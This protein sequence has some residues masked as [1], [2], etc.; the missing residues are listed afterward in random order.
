MKEL[1]LTICLLIL[2][3]GGFLQAQTDK[4]RVAV[5][6]PTGNS[7]DEGIIMATRELV[8]SALVNTG[9]YDIVERSLLDRILREQKF[10]NSGAVDASQVSELGRLVGANK[11]VLAVVTSMGKRALLSIKMVDVESAMVESQKTKTL[12]L[13]EL[14]DWIEPLTLE[15]IG[16]AVEAAPKAGGVFSIGS[17][18]DRKGN[19]DKK[20][21]KEKEKQKQKEKEKEKEKEKVVQTPPPPKTDKERFIERNEEDTWI[22]PAPTTNGKDVVFEFKG[23]KGRKNPIVKLYLDGSPIG[24]GTLNEGFSIKANVRPGAYTIKIEWENTIADTSFNINT[25]KKHHYEFEYKTTG[26]GY[27]FTLKK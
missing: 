9:K 18:F 17:L 4:S 12:S 6:D 8:S 20:A 19:S 13:D 24:T 23:A 7:L 5:F 2:G 14:L 21:S 1:V 3:S 16:E 11:A 22:V 10:S 15:M 26:F 25:E 27:A